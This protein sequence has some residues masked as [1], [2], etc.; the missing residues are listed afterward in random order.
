MGSSWPAAAAE[1][2]LIGADF[3]SEERVRMGAHANVRV[4]SEPRALLRLVTE[5]SYS[6]VLIDA[7]WKAL[8]T[9][10]R[11]SL[12]EEAGHGA[13]CVFV[14]TERLRLFT[15]WLA[16]EDRS[17]SLWS[18]IRNVVFEAPGPAR[19][20][21]DEA[22]EPERSLLVPARSAARVQEAR[23]RVLDAA[24]KAR[25]ELLAESYSTQQVATLLRVSRQTPHDRVKAKALLA[26]EDKNS[27]WFPAF[28]FDA[29]G[30]SGVVQG[31]PEV[32][33]LLAVGPVAQARWLSRPSAVLEGRSPM[34][35]LKAGELARVKGEARGV[36]AQAGAADG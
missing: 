17:V 19:E 33:A 30:P 23:R 13:P 36:T 1:R 6:L 7:G 28:Q 22:R 27:L 15:R 11:S 14:Q 18:K 4:E 5:E 2:Y 21:H 3:P 29:D 34:Q 12:T 24:F 16:T 8:S 10:M 20:P 9:S 31:L 26:I 25:A 35:A 32:L